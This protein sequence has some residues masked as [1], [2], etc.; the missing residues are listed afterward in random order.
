MN[1]EKALRWVVLGGIFLLPFIV[2][3]VSR[4]LF[5]PFIT[6]KNFAFRIIVEIIAGGYIALALAYPAYRPKRTL[7]LW[8]FAAF[9]AIMAVAD[10]FGTYP[11]KSFWS[12]YE[13]ME[14]WVTLA[15]L[16]AYF[17]VIGAMLKTKELWH[18]WWHTSLAV[19]GLV[20]TYALLQLAGLIVINQ[21]GIRLDAT[22]G[23]ATYLGVYMLFHVC[24]TALLLIREYRGEIEIGKTNF[25]YLVAGALQIPVAVLASTDVGGG[26]GF[27]AF[28]IFS[29]VIWGY[30]WARSSGGTASRVVLMVLMAAQA[31]ALFF[32][33]TRGAILGLLGAGV[34]AGLIMVVR[35]RGSHLARGAIAALIGLVVLI[36]IFALV[37]DQQWV[38]NIE[39]LYRLSTL[40]T[41][42]TTFS[43]FMNW[44]MAWEGFKERPILG[45][46]QENYAAVFDKHYDPGMWG[47][48]PWFDRVHNVVFD[49]LIAG[50]ILGLLSYLSLHLVALWM[51]WRSA[52]FAAYEKA[53]LTG[54]FAGYFFYLLFTFDNLTSYLFFVA[55]LAYI[56]TRASENDP[57]STAPTS[58]SVLPWAA[59]GAILVVWLVAWFV[60]ADAIAQ[61]RLVI[62]AL[63]PQVG[64]PTQNLEFFKQAAAMHGVGTQEAREQF[65]QAAIAVVGAEGVETSLKEGFMRG[66]FEA[67]SMQQEE[68][69]LNARFPFFTGIL[70]DHSGL[71]VEAKKELDRAHEL[72]PKKQS[73]LYELGLN[74][75]AR[76]AP[77]EAVGFFKEAY[78]LEM[79]NTDAKRYY[80]AALIRAEKDSV[81]D[82]ILRE[83]VESDEAADARI[84]QAL[85]SRGM[86]AGIAQIWKMHT[87]K[88]P[89]DVEA[90]FVLVGALYQAKETALALQELEAIKR[91]HPAAGEQVDQ[92][93]AD[94]KKGV[95]P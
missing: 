33:S 93:I 21:G 66:A 26:N 75:F 28:L 44:G 4:S 52:L 86:Y 88:H 51:L 34:L 71:Y 74:A 43:R 59:G 73:I 18:K 77:D 80:V 47:Q 38:K 42:K 8:A 11:L 87:T 6:G 31:F 19:S 22:F 30:A 20:A 94:I 56:A 13:R 65:S 39:P 35:D 12:N 83:L 29:L 57:E 1:L 91:E 54:L 81:A 84:A 45:W 60:N 15:H 5:F 48:E 58:P 53:I 95:T 55:T 67:M 69:P 92:F 68:A 24:I 63:S 23:N 2:L 70:L 78:E 25:Y 61:N 89:E 32:T 82:P 76:S 7:L 46:G 40:L 50:G 27:I 79:K 41:D 64:G 14:G 9:V 10:I 3:Y 62:R 37:K 36:G 72:S 17:V 85:A 90:R 49:W 16:F